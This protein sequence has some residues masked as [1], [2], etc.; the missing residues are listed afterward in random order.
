MSPHSHTHRAHMQP[1]TSPTHTPHTHSGRRTEEPPSDSSEIDVSSGS[2]GSSSTA[3]NGSG[4]RR[5]GQRSA[6]GYGSKRRQHDQVVRGGGCGGGGRGRDGGG[7]GA[8]E[9]GRV[10][11]AAPPAEHGLSE[12]APD[13][14]PERHAHEGREARRGPRGRLQERNGQG[15][16]RTPAKVREEADRR[17][18]EGAEGADG[19]DDE[20]HPRGQH[21]I[22]GLGAVAGDGQVGGEAGAVG[23]VGVAVSGAGR[24]Q[25]LDVD[26]AVGAWPVKTGEDDVRAVAQGGA[27]TGHELLQGGA[28]RRALGDDVRGPEEGVQAHD[29]RMHR[30]VVA[31]AREADAVRAVGEV[32]VHGTDGA[33]QRRERRGARGADGDGAIAINRRQQ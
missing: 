3:E 7:K 21:A 17:G 19:K 12:A 10:V 6:P 24:I 18:P 14:M 27:R 23:V 1:T 30:R 31:D 8:M 25:G 2:T 4:G 22:L 11:H 5:S 33:L 32:A 20:A 28:T 13:G 26:Q 15:A 29:E 16:P 9:R